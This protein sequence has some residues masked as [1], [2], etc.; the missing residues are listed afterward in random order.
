MI[1]QDRQKIILDYAAKYGDNRA[2]KRF[3]INGETLNRYR[4]VSFDQIPNSATSIIIPDLHCPYHDMPAIRLMMKIVNDQQF[5]YDKTILLGDVVDFYGV[6]RFDKDPNRKD[7][8]QFEA[9]EA[10][11][12]L[13]TMKRGLPETEWHYLKGNHEARLKKFLMS[14]ARAL[15]NLRALKVDNLLRL[16]E[17][18]IKYIEKSWNYY[19]TVMIKHGNKVGKY[20]GY[21]AHAEMLRHMSLGISAHTHRLAIVNYTADGID[22]QWVECGHLCDV[23]KADYMEDYP[24]WQQGFCFMHRDGKAF[25]FDLVRYYRDEKAVKAFYCGKKY[26]ERLK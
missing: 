1:S 19:D 7:D 21:S 12:L 25:S 5:N 3:K 20:S 6:S 10:F 22:I 17:L 8:I 16:N 24:N 14:N 15:S 23:M 18:D 9:D 4:R 2:L 11:D 26:S 13:S